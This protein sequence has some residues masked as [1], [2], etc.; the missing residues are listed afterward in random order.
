[1]GYFQGKAVA[2]DLIVLNGLEKA[3]GFD[4]L[5]QDNEKY[6][7]LLKGAQGYEYLYRVNCGGDEYK[8]EYGR[9][10]FV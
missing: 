10:N 1:M 2:E 6:G 9:N 5:Y 4:A 8:D 7:A 3:P